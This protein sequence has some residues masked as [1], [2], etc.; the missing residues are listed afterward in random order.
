MESGAELY[1]VT[2]RSSYEIRRLEWSLNAV[3]SR[4]ETGRLSI[5]PHQTPARSSSRWLNSWTIPMIRKGV[6]PAVSSCRPGEFR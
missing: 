5:V 6:R 1:G 2:V 3:P 4:S